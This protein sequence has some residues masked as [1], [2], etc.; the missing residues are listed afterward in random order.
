[1]GAHLVALLPVLLLLTTGLQSAVLAETHEGL[2]LQ[3]AA[4][5]VDASCRAGP[6]QQDTGCTATKYHLCSGS[7]VSC[8]CF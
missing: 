3:P 5:R 1:M 7:C 6:V 4:R 2:R 8:L